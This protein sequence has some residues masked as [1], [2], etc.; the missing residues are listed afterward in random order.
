MAMKRTAFL[1]I[2]F[3]TFCGAIILAVG[4][5][6]NIFVKAYQFSQASRQYSLVI[7]EVMVQNRNFQQDPDGDYSNYAEIYNT[8]D[9]TVSLKG[10]GLSDDIQNLFLW[11]FPNVSIPPHGFLVVWISGKNKSEASNLHTNFKFKKTDSAVILASPD[12]T[13]KTV[14]PVISKDANIS[15]GR[16]PDGGDRFYIFDGGTIGR[17]NLLS[18]LKTGA[19]RLADV[20]FSRQ[21]GY[22]EKETDVELTENEQGVTIRYTLDGSEPG[23]NASVYQAGKPIRLAMN[24]ITVIRA[25]AYKA[26]YPKSNIVTK[27]Y[28]VAQ[29]ICRKYKIPAV[30]L[31]ADPDDLFDYTKGIYIKGKVYDDW[32]KDN[33]QDVLNENP[34]ANYNQKGKLWERPAH[35]ELFAPDGTAGI[36]QN[37]GIRMHGGY[38]LR[39]DDK[40]LQLIA[41]ADYDDKKNFEYN[42]FDEI[43]GGKKV[44]SILIRTSG[45]DIKKSLFRDS[46]I[47]SLA[48]TASLDTQKSKPCI[49]FINGV[50]Y[51][52]HSFRTTYDASYISAKY[53]IDK[54]DAVII[55][56]PSGDIGDKVKEGFPG[57]EFQYA[58][59]YQFIKDND[60]S[61][62][63]NYAYVKTLMDTDNY[64]EY[65][66]LEIYSGNDDWPANN[67]S[68]WRKRT[69]NYTPDAAYGSDGRWR[70]LVYDLD[71]GFGL[72]EQSVEFD[73]L[74]MATAAQSDKEN[75]PPHTTVMFRSLL[76]NKDFRDNFINRFA[77]LLNTNFESTRVMSKLASM[78]DVYAP[79]VPDHLKKWNLLET[80]IDNWYAEIDAMMQYAKNRPAAIRQQIC[81]YFNISVCG[82]LVKIG[83]GGT[84]KIN[85]VTLNPGQWQGCYFSDP[86]ITLEAVPQQGFRFAG[87]SG[88]AVSAQSALRL[89][90]A[91]DTELEALFEK[92]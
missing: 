74:E 91:P 73:S 8:S 35:V 66:I 80:D 65:N 40:S 78:R 4:F 68:V 92:A 64:I 52:I 11:T 72:F 70:W 81:K 31:V 2:I 60:M 45:T 34:P 71:C 1:K 76:N 41:D 51:G 26:G 3:I 37:I 13:W 16:Q 79:Y 62:S 20:A 30:S 10:F 50:Y 27:T 14:F 88:A 39:Y 77:D 22:F 5:G 18:P 56:D 53:N 90:L 49:L 75:N 15:C 87:W 9:D 85:S 84:V 54:E 6:K 47:Q 83:Q 24:S 59:L 19:K 44:E 58:M 29:G 7:N 25:R 33:P 28:F 32:K 17:S 12:R 82:L 67:I 55:K 46:F 86:P 63:K 23:E 48:D 57:D 42:F 38:S 36:S 43:S 21:A 69:N 89:Y 61:D